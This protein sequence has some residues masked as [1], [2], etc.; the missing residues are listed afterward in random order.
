M[1]KEIKD[2]SKII[3]VRIRNYQKLPDFLKRRVFKNENHS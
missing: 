2:E 3:K 1:F